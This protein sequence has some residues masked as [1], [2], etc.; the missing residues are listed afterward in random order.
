VVLI[1][2]GRLPTSPIPLL[3]RGALSFHQIIRD[4]ETPMVLPNQEPNKPSKPRKSTKRNN[5]R[6][7]SHR[8]PVP[9]S[10]VALPVVHPD[11]AG[12]D[13][14]SDMHMVCVPA[15][16]AADR[17]RQFGANTADLQEIVTWL[18]ECGVKTVALESTGVYW[19]P[20]FELLE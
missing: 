3:A 4:P 13:V 5:R 15:D 9:D 2:L 6:A 20:L 1:P 12:I 8:V 18:K 10:P 14:H 16:R 11:A 19:I 17:V 7:R